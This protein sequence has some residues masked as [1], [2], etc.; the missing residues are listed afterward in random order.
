VTT[1]QLG[2]RI[3]IRI[4]G[5][6]IPQGSKTA[7][8]FGNG[9]RDA[10]AKTLKPWRDHV[11]LTTEDTIRYHDGLPLTGPVAVWLRFTF[12]RPKSHFRTGRNAHL[13]R[14]TAP[15]FPGHSC[16]DIDKLQ[17]AIFDALTD[18]K[19]WADDTQIT[20]LRRVRKFYAGEDEYALDRPGVDV[21]IEDLVPQAT[22]EGATR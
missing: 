18:A 15:L 6:P 7:N 17:R 19:V 10:N 5:T 13:L 11:R 22:I 3:G 1:T 16:G 8:H 4:Y 2:T 14:D 9:V 12:A 21:V 20:D